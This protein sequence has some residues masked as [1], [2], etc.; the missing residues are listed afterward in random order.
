MDIFLL[1]NFYQT[2]FKNTIPSIPVLYFTVLVVIPG[3]VCVNV[4][5]IKLHQTAETHAMCVKHD[6]LK[7]ERYL[8]F[9]SIAKAVFDEIPSMGSP[10][11]TPRPINSL[12]QLRP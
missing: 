3:P 8:A 11:M 9:R 7:K 4:F 10:F 12:L 2:I 6:V 5:V 1:N